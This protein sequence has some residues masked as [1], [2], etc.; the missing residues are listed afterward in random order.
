MSQPTHG[1][2]AARSV[3]VSAAAAVG[4]GAL[5]VA[6]AAQAL[7]S[8]PTDNGATVYVNDARRPGL[9]TGSI[10]NVT[11]SKLEGFGNVF[12]HVDAPAE[13]APR[14]NDQMM[15]GFGLT[16]GAAGSYR[17]TRSVRL[18]DV[19]MT[20]KVQVSGAASTT[21]F[22]DTFTNTATEPVTLEVSFG[23]SLGNGLTSTTSPNK[24]TISDSSSG[25]AVVD[26]S[27]TWIAAT[28]PG[29]TRPTGVVVGS[30]VDSLAD[31]QSDPFT[32]AYVAT[33]SRANDLGF[34]RELTIEPGT[35]ESLMQYAV[36][37]A[38]SDTTQIA[39]DTAA[40]AGAPDFSSLTLDEICTLQNWDLASY[41]AACVGAEPLQLPAADVEVEHTTDVAYDV[42]GKTIA[43]LQADMTA[44]VVTSVDITKAYLDRIEAYDGGALGFHALHHRRPGRRRPGDGGRR[45]AGRRRVGR[46]AG[47]PDRAQG[48]LRHRG[49]AHLRRHPGAR[50]LGAGQGRLAGVQAACRRC[51][52]H[53]QGQPVGVRQ[54]GL[55]QRQR[56]QADLER[57]LPVEDLV[58]LQR[59]LGHRGGR[60]PGRRRD[61]HPDRGLAVR[62]RRPA[63]ACRRSAAP[64]A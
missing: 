40:L 37:G 53:R 51:G 33:G 54:L 47:H 18:G 63:R 9:D 2:R 50:G 44:G 11:G 31:Q 26:P 45:G 19:L 4:L 41:D 22:F 38:L 23:G 64:T 59:R 28:T 16:A 1:R 42:T 30:G 49:H 17:S 57:A 62:P 39:T 15:R 14:M 48:P 25:D 60:R 58:R 7:T 24:A 61:G 6:P 56:L 27:D 55:V 46:P 20:R 21:S 12:V 29:D 52:D 36:I 10:R 32:T 34:V 3:A 43:Q 13:D 35:T 8:V 5:A